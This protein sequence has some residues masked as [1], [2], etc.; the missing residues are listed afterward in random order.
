LHGLAGCAFAEASG[1]ACAAGVVGGVAQS[2]YAGYLGRNGLTGQAYTQTAALIG[3]LAGYFTSGGKGEN[4]SLASTTARSGLQNN[5]LSHG[6][7]LEREIAKRELAACFEAGDCSDEQISALSSTIDALDFIDANRDSYLRESCQADPRGASCIAAIRELAFTLEL[8]KS[9]QDPFGIGS[10]TDQIELTFTNAQILDNSGAFQAGSAGDLTLTGMVSEWNQ[11]MGLLAAFSTSWDVVQEERGTENA[12]NLLSATMNI[13]ELGGVAA[14]ARGGAAPRP[15]SVNREP[16]AGSVENAN[17]AQ[18]N[19]IPTTKEFTLEGSQIYSNLVGRPIKT[20]GDLTAALRSGAIRPNQI[21]VDF[22]DMNGTRLILNTRT[23]TALTNAGIP[24]SQ[25][26]GRN[27]TGA[28]AYTE[29]N[30]TVRTFDYLASQQLSNNG[31][32]PT[33]A[34]NLP[35]Q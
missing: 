7:A 15:A 8:F 24:R 23:S 19:R 5:Y 11:G 35:G 13:L 1:G 30:G 31:L 3:G 18:N 10:I 17:F 33:G 25:W 32:P 29:A 34:P 21:P 6:E 12:L 4:V 26:Y 27:Q 20:V 16:S 22:V 28:T 2:V 9:P 14:V